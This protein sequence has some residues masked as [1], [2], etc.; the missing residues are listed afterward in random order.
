MTTRRSSWSWAIRQLKS[1]FARTRRN[2]L[3]CLQNMINRTS[4]PWARFSSSL[5]TPAAL[6]F[7]MPEISTRKMWWHKL[8]NPRQLFRWIK[9]HSYQRR[10]SICN[11]NCKNSC[12]L[13]LKMK[14]V[15]LKSI[16]PRS[17]QQQMAPKC[18][19]S[20]ADLILSRILDHRI[21]KE[22][23]NKRQ[24]KPHLNK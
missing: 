9:S 8:A 11:E 2:L 22:S 21:A 23:I 15:S 5:Q 6:L 1:S 7:G 16:T 19:L 17:R 20:V 13:Q 12:Y 18:S 14:M 10:K 3:S 24:R 4:Q